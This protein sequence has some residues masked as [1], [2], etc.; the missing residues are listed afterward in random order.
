MDD[1]KRGLDDLLSDLGIGENE[2][3]PEVVP[4]EE[5]G[6]IVAP[7][8]PQED[9]KSVLE[10]FLV[11]LLLRLDPAYSVD[12]Q[13]QENLFRVEVLGGDSGRVI[14]REGRTLQSLEFLTNVVMAKHFG[15]AY[16][17]VLDAA[18]LP[19]GATRSASVGWLPTPRCRWR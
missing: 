4:R 2:A 17:V 14:G 18:W 8:P 3:A 1:K 19:A 12:V 7:A 5:E 10:N 15:P 6:P 13:Q 16:R 9:P 11:G